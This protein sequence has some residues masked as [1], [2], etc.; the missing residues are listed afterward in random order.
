MRALGLTPFLLFL[1]AACPAAAADLC[2][3]LFVPDGYAL[4]CETRIEGGKRNEQVVVQPS[5]GLTLAELTLRP[6]DKAEEPLA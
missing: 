4:V 5:N 3:S 2:G 1:L 6:L